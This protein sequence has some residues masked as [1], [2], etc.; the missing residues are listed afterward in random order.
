MITIN[1]SDEE[2]LLLYDLLSRLP[3]DQ[4]MLDL[5]DDTDLQVIWN[6]ESSL[7]KQLIEPLSNDYKQLVANARAQQRVAPKE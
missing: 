3:N 1:L 7:E 6:L 4:T 5:S 2:A